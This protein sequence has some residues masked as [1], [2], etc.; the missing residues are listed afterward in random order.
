MFQAAREQ[1]DLHEFTTLLMRLAEYRPAFDQPNNPPPP[2]RLTTHDGPR[3]IACCTTS[4]MAGPQE[5]ARLAAGFRGLRDVA[6]LPNPG[7]AG[8]DLPATLTAALAQHAAA[9]RDHARGEPYVLMGHSAGGL[10]ANALA[11]H[12]ED[13]G[14]GPEAVVLIDS[15][16]PADEILGRWIPEMLQGLEGDGEAFT[17]LSDDRYTAWAHYIRL[18]GDWS[19]VKTTAPTLLVRCDQPLGTVPDDR[20]WRP[21]WPHEHTT[22]DS[23][24]DHFTMLGEHA[25]TTARIVHEWLNTLGK[26]E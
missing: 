26:A 12:L 5:Y 6:V 15:Y 24:G 23:T 17:G 22:A 9:V 4:L 13:E 16:P 1:D 8:E 10:V 18:Y 11:R 19:P 21:A 7:F 20:D 14:G 25:P 3:V 2:L